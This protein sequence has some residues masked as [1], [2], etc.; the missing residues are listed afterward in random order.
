MAYALRIDSID[1][2]PAAPARRARQAYARQ[3]R[4][5]APLAQPGAEARPG[6]P[7]R[8]PAPA[9]QA[10]PWPALAPATLVRAAIG[11]VAELVALPVTGA[12]MPDALL[13]AGDLVM[14]QP[15]TAIDH[16]ALHAVTWPGQPEPL[17]RRLFVT[18]Q[19]VRLQ[20]ENRAWPAE[21][22]PC[23]EVRVAGRVVAVVRQRDGAHLAPPAAR[24]PGG[25]HAPA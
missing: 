25:G 7:P 1:E 4:L 12:G 6:A 21:E 23:S 5:M 22:R 17:L 2:R 13:A 20:P 24:A 8:S 15:A 9:A 19:G 3:L 10:G 11:Q 14:L 16:G 18:S